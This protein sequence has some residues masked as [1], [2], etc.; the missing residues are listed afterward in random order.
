LIIEILED[1]KRCGH[2]GE[3]SNLLLGYLSSVSRKLSTPLALLV[4]SRSASGKTTLQDAILS[5]TPPEDYEKYTRLTDQALFYKEEEALKNKLLAIEEEKGAAGSAY[6]LRNLQSSQGLSIAVT[7][8]DPQSGKLKTQVN[9]VYGPTAIMVTTTYSEQLD[10]ETYNRFI[11]LTVDESAAQTRKIL[12][13]QRI[14]ESIEGIIAK[15]NKEVIQRKHHNAQRLLM[16]MEVANPYSKQLTFVDTILR[17]RREQPK[18]LTIIKGVALLRQY[19]KEIKQAEYAEEKIEYIEVD[20]KDIEIANKIANEILGRNLDELC[21]PARNLLI[22]IRAM[23]EEI[24]VL[25]AVSWQNVVFTRREVR[26]HTQWSDYQVRSHMKQLEELE[27]LYP[28]NGGPGK[29]YAYQLLWDG[30]GMDGNKF[31]MGLIDCDQL[32]TASMKRGTARVEGK[33]ASMKK[34][35]ARVEGKT[36]SMKKGTVRVEGKTAS[37][38]AKTASMKKGTARVL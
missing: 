23:A 9:Q 21:P 14:N 38:N 32:K 10:F 7:T 29:R 25:N 28:V 20:I 34:G 35:T 19:Q 6:S 17:A 15:R 2:V 3:E 1:F 31:M 11:V 18:Y 13:R 26:E 22:E 4:V 16:Q 36:A 12:E 8:K 30:R 24:S 27:Y 37:L 5:F 33:T